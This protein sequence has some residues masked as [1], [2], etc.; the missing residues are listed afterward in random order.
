MDSMR[1]LVINLR[2]AG[3]TPSWSQ[4]YTSYWLFIMADPATGACLMIPCQTESSLLITSAW[5][6]MWMPR[7]ISHCPHCQAAATALPFPPL[8]QLVCVCVQARIITRLVLNLVGLISI[9]SKRWKEHLCSWNHSGWQIQLLKQPDPEGF[10]KLNFLDP[11]LS[12]I[13]A[14]ASWIWTAIKQ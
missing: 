8:S 9:N 5:W 1:T 3:A 13:E 14:E 12:L 4:V 10:H 11:E 6:Y 2:I 7:L